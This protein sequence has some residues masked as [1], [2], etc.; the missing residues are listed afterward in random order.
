MT[1]EIHFYKTPH[2]TYE[3]KEIYAE[4][5]EN[6]RLVFHKEVHEGKCTPLEIELLNRMSAGEIKF[7]DVF[8]R[9]KK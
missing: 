6:T 7:T 4:V 2:G 1:K 3:T 9:K 5:P 8:E